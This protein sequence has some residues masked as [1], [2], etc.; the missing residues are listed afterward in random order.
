MVGLAFKNDETKTPKVR[1][2]GQELRCRHK[3]QDL[4]FLQGVFSHCTLII[5]L[6]LLFNLL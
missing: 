1:Q 4:R 2:L 3:T 5:Y 6:F